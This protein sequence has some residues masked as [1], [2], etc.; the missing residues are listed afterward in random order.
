MTKYVSTEERNWFS[1][2]IRGMEMKG[3]TLWNDSHDVSTLIYRMPKGLQIPLHKHEV[4]VQVVV[5]SGKLHVS[6]GDR[7]LGPGG[8]YFV[9]PGDSHVETALEDTEILVIKKL[10]DPADAQQRLV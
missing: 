8:F 3:S 4:W 9:E 1:A 7:T 2:S 10:P 5:L 6:I